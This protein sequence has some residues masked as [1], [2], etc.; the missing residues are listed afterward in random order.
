MDKQ[1][2]VVIVTGGS[3]GIGRASADYLAEK[4]DTVYSFSRHGESRAGVDHIPCDVTR[5]DEVREAVLCVAKKEGHID[6]LICAAGFG[7]SGVTEKTPLPLARKQLNVNFFGV[8]SVV[9][10]V[11]PFIRAQGRGRI[12]GISSLAAVFPIPFQSFYS[13]SKAALEAYFSALANEVRPFGISVC[14]I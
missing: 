11:L 3:S 4:G 7:I 5:E 14:C 10:A 13:A 8:V 12:V 1:R 9:S 6:L 2:G